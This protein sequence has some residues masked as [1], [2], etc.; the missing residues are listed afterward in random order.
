[1]RLSIRAALCSVALIA[2]A[3]VPNA[4]L[5]ARPEHNAVSGSFV[6][7]DFCGT[8]AAIAISFTG[9]FNIEYGSDVIRVRSQEKVEFTNPANGMKVD[10]SVVGYETITFTDLGDGTVLREHTLRGAPSTLKTYH[11]TVLLKDAGYLV[12][13]EHL[14]A[15]GNV[16]STTFGTVHGP[17]PGAATDFN[18]FCGVMA[19]ALGI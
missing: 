12:V 17:H 7:P 2:F 15:D 16:L 3:I 6:D 5:A 19:D 4:A 11:G 10:Q 18:L 8:G 1:M 9:V 13:D 14:D